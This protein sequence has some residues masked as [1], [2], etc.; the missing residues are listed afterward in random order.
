MKPDKIYW[1]PHILRYRYKSGNE[2][3]HEEELLSLI[4]KCLLENETKRD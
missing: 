3:V 4:L 2:K 1:D